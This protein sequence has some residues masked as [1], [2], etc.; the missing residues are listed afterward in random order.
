MQLLLDSH[1]LLWWDGDLEKLSA[2]QRAA[3]SD[4]DNEV[5]VSAVTPWELGIKSAAGKLALRDSVRGLAAKFGFIEL[6]I[7]LSH[8]EAAASLPLVHK[9][10]FDR[11]LVAQAI[12]EGMVLV[13]ADGRLREDPVEIL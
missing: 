3:I 7:T 10:P 8:G 6:P 11:M 2:A 1:A 4:P 13:T 5:F 9:D 12:V